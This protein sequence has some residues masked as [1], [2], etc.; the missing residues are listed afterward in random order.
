V[1]QILSKNTI[2]ALGYEIAKLDGFLANPYR[3]AITASGLVPE[4]HPNQ[5][6]RQT[7]AASVLRYVPETQTTIIGAYRY[8]TDDWHIHAHTPE[9][10]VVQQVGAFADASVGYRYYHQS[11][12][13]FYEKRYPAP[14]P[15]TIEYVTD[16][17]KMSAYDGHVFEAKLGILGEEFGLDRSWGGARFEGILEYVIQHNR[18]GNAVVAHVALTVPFEY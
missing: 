12:A 14:V 6:L 8:Y 2:A 1:S 18:F 4:K 17:P 9:L 3:L 5:R 10:R 11:A 16:D 7:I 15:N 13:F